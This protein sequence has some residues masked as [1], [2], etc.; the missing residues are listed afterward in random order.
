MIT[1]KPYPTDLTDAE[2]QLIQPFL[3][4]PPLPHQPGRRIEYSY[5]EILNAILYLLRNACSWRALPHDLPP[6]ESVRY[7][8]RK[9]VQNGLLDRIHDTLRHQLRLQA[10]KEPTPSA[11][12]IDSQSVKTGE[13]GGPKNLRQL[14][15][16]TQARRSRGSN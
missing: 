2:W 4:P 10:G 9:W 15:G 3:P 6:H 5:R 11:M 12:I 7:H 14:S 13:K 1:R 16:M 8:F